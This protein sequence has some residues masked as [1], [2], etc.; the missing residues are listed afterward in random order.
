MKI[1]KIAFFEK[2]KKTVLIMII[3]LSV[4][5]ISTALLLIFGHGLPYGH[6]VPDCNDDLLISYS[7]NLNIDN[8]FLGDNEVASVAT[9]YSALYKNGN[10]RTMYVCSIPL[11]YSTHEK[12]YSILNRDIV[13]IDDNTYSTQNSD[14]TIN[15]FRNNIWMG[16]DGEWVQLN[17][18]ESDSFFIVN[19]YGNLYQDD[20][21]GMCYSFDETRK[22]VVTPAYNGITITCEIDPGKDMELPIEYS[23]VKVCNKS[24]GY[25]VLKDR[26]VNSDLKG[27]RFVITRPVVS[28]ELGKVYV[29]SPIKIHEG[30]RESKLI[31]KIPDGALGKI[32]LTFSINYYCENMFFDC[33]AYQRNSKVNYIFDSYVAF[34][35]V[36]PDSGTYNYLKFNIRSFTPKKSKLLD[37]VTLNF[38]VL[39]CQDETDVEIYSV[40]RDW[41]SWQLTWKNKPKFNEKIGEFKVSGSGWYSIDLTQYAK[42]LIDDNYYNLIDNTIMLKTK[43]ESKG[44]VI[45][46]TTDNSVMPPFFEVHYRTR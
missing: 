14:Y 8:L 18:T 12:K 38:F 39:Y 25:I 32:T 46:T 35:S 2:N 31:Y 34:D 19:H 17:L 9:R 6:N 40:R 30:S 45:F 27:N 41:C 36:T 3:L 44:Y 20:N 1:M 13:Q 15:Y 43:D 26:Q 23:G 37:S 33:A 42:R 11:R 24:A 7:R 16:D 28:D 5:V 22:M 4:M 21:M 10:Y 29:D